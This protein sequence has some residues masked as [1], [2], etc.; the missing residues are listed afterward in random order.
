M[1]DFIAASLPRFYCRALP[2]FSQIGNQP[3]EIIDNTLPRRYIADFQETRQ[4]SY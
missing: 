2:R 1:I 4:L 3:I